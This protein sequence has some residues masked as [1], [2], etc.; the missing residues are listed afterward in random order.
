MSSQRRNTRKTRRRRME[1]RKLMRNHIPCSWTSTQSASTIHC[2]CF[3]R[4]RVSHKYSQMN[5]CSCCC[6]YSKFLPGQVWGSDT[7]QWELT[8][9][10]TTFTSM[11]C[12]QMIFSEATWKISPLRMRTKVYFSWPHLSTKTQKKLICTIVQSDLVKSRT[13]LW[14]PS[15][16]H[17]T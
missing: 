3:L 13:G 11:C 15:F 4:S 6:N 14:E 2:S 7:T 1:S 17:L 12:T 5:W 16:C 8:V 9:L 10:S